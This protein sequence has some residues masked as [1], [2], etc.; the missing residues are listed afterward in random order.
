MTD[1]NGIS[2]ALTVIGFICT[3]AIVAG[4]IALLGLI[5]ALITALLFDGLPE[6]IKKIRGK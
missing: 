1:L 5:V 2:P 6:L 4:A 3:I